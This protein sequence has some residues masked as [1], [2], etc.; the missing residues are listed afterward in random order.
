M[1]EPAGPV[2]GRVSSSVAIFLRLHDHMTTVFLRVLRSFFLCTH[3]PF[4][5]TYGLVNWLVQACI[6]SLL[7]VYLN[8]LYLTARTLQRLIHSSHA[9]WLSSSPWA[10]GR[11]AC[12]ALGC[13][14]CRGE[15]HK[16]LCSLSIMEKTTYPG[17]HGACGWEKAGRRSPAWRSRIQNPV[18]VQHWTSVVHAP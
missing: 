12:V 4:C 17:T 11:F 2:V 15:G 9:L 10:D 6:A 8:S 14:R 13:A 18:I 7:S 3:V 16:G 5:I 1:D